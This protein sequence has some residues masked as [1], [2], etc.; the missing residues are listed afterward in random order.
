MLKDFY[1][2][3]YN[4]L[5]LVWSQNIS[6]SDSSDYSNEEKHII[7]KALKFK[8]YMNSYDELQDAKRYADNKDIK[9]VIRSSASAV[10]A[11][12]KYHCEDWHISYP[13]A[14]IPFDEKIENI[15]INAQKPPYYWK[16]HQECINLLHL[17]R[18]RNSMHEGECYYIDKN[19]KEIVTPDI[20]VAKLFMDSAKKFILWLDSLT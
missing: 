10:E 3:S 5:N 7:E 9:G 12:L 17:Y 15:L 1:N 2:N 11:A 19:S 4:E 16:D 8:R 13:R 14:K 20:S 6:L 18:A